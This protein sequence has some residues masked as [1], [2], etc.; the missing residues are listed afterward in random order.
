MKALLWVGLGSGLGGAL[1]YGT[2][3]AAIELAWTDFPISTLCVNLI[4]SLLIGFLAGILGSGDSR[5]APSYKRQFWVTGFCGGYTT[6]SAFSWEIV[7][8][9]RG[10]EGTLAGAYAAGS[11]FLGLVAVAIGLILAMRWNARSGEYQR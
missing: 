9:V 2:N 4:G 7:E 11:I 8:L 10:G 3:W 1:R 5:P 6:F